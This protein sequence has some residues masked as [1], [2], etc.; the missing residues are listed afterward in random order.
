MKKAWI[1]LTV[2]F[3][4]VQLSAQNCEYF[5]KGNDMVQDK[6]CAPVAAS[7]EITYGGL[8]Y[9]G[10][11]VQ[12]YIDWDDGTPPELVDP[13]FNAALN[14]WEY[15]GTHSYPKGGDQCNYET[16]TM[17][18]VDGEMCTSS[19]QTQQVTVWDTDDENGGVMSITPE[20]FPICLGNDGTVTFT[21][22][23]Q[24]NCV[25]PIEEDRKNTNS[26]WIQ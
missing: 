3:W 13:T 18:V 1:V 21:D 14:R 17:L 7:W 10:P 12:F 16:R 11:N 4:A 22:A 6:P 24:W 15:T 23:S 9:T 19:I 25:P 8:S 26:R 5:S 20:V 2:A